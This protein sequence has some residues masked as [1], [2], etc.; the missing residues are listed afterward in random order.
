[1]SLASPLEA[2]KGLHPGRDDIIAAF[3][4]PTSSG[5]G[6]MILPRSGALA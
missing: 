4:R 6:P 3:D 1:M 5:D 2:V